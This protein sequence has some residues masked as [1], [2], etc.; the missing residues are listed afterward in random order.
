LHLGSLLTAAASYLDARQ[1]SGEWLVRIEDIDPPRE[2][3]G[4][5]D[6]ILRALER[7]DLEWDRDVLYQSRRVPVYRDVADRLCRNGLAYACSCTR[8]ML[9]GAGPG[10]SHA[11]RYPGT[12]RRK[13][14]HRRAT[15]LRIRAPSE[16]VGFD[17]R[18][19]GPQNH[20]IG[21]ASGDYVI[22]RRDGLPAYHL[23]AVVDDAH[24]RITHIV[25]GADLLTSTAPHI[26]LQRTLSLPSPSYCHLP[27]IVNAAGRKLSKQTG[28]AAIALDRPGL[29]ALEVLRH[30]GLTPPPELLGAP[31]R[32]LWD[33]ARPRW[34]A[35]LLAG[36]RTLEDRGVAVGP[37]LV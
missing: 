4:A 13:T 28:A 5:A 22:F 24:Q 25:R 29:A 12:C 1:H 7:F 2:V 21:T 34:N 35:D 23:A 16:P 37:P 14:R 3:P 10:K 6:A 31:P 36:V 30:L 11:S 27:V 20:D 17:D 32:E 15:A 8:S 9:R 18:L 26:H 19:Q 33:W